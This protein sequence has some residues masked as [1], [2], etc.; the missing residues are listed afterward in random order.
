VRELRKQGL[1]LRQIGYALTEWSMY[2]RYSRAWQP[3]SVSNLLKTWEE[4]AVEAR[5]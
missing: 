1:S 3:E 2:P 5:S 4:W